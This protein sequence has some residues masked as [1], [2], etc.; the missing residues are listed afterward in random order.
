M[1][2]Y[3]IP[4]PAANGGTNIISQDTFAASG[5]SVSGT[6]GGGG[7]GGGV[8]QIIAGTNITISPKEGTGVVT[9][10]ATGGGSYVPDAQFSSITMQPLTGYISTAFITATGDGLSICPAI[11]LATADNDIRA[12]YQIGFQS[13]SQ[14]TINQGILQIGK[15][16]WLGVDGKDVTGLAATS[17]STV[18]GAFQPICGSELYVNNSDN[19]GNGTGRISY[20]DSV[21]SMNLEAAG[22]PITI[23][24]LSVSSIN[25]TSINAFGGTSVPDAQ[26][27]SITMNVNGYMST[28][29]VTVTSLGGNTPGMTFATRP[30][31]PTGSCPI[32]FN[33]AGQ[34]SIDEGQLAV[35]KSSWIGVDSAP[36][37]GL[38]VFAFSTILGSFQPVCCGDLYINNSDS[39]GFGTGLM[40]YVDSLSTLKLEAAGGPVTVSTLSVSSIGGISWDRIST[41][42]GNAPA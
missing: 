32:V 40:S 34:E 22:G 17:F 20:I 7:G 5:A 19:T 24:T 18:Y 38:G 16:Y 42:I 30:T 11:T 3:T 39:G 36:V 1:S 35:A 31:V 27:S 21:S 14:S 2:S 29:N 26:F 9:I 12:S 13:G 10:D 15:N 41:V 4:G 28:G 25:G 8:T 37:S 6:G 23:S 33:S